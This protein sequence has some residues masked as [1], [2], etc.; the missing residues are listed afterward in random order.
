MPTPAQF[1]PL[2]ESRTSKVTTLDEFVAECLSDVDRFKTMWEAE[3]KKNPE[4]F[5]AT[6]SQGDWFEQFLTFI[7]NGDEGLEPGA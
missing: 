7:T 4:H 1:T 3:G 6:L 5:P 2:I